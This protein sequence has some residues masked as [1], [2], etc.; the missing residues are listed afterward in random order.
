MA[1]EREEYGFYGETLKRLRAD[2]R[3]KDKTFYA[4]VGGSGKK[5]NQEII[6]E[7]TTNCDVVIAGV[8][9]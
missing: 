5:L 3:Y 1:K 8:G 9:D 2:E 6:D 7:Y 4:Y